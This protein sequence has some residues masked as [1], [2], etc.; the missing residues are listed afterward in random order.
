MWAPQHFAL[1][2]R[3]S[4]AGSALDAATTAWV[5]AVFAVDGTVVGDARKTLVNNLIVDLKADGVWTK[6][7]RLWLFAMENSTGALVDIVADSLATAVSSPTFTADAGYTGNGSSHIDSNFDPSTAGGNFAQN[8]ACLFAWSNSS[9]I[10]ASNIL[11]GQNDLSDKNVIIPRQSG[12]FYSSCNEGSSSYGC[13]GTVADSIGLFLVDRNAASGAG[14][15][16]GYLNGAQVA[17]GAIASGLMV[18]ANFSFLKGSA[19]GTYQCSAGGF[20]AHLTSIDSA[21]LYSR[22]RTYMT[23]VGVP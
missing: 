2:G 9:G 10:N 4:A 17:T 23:A 21:N 22:L 19:Y 11:C 5:D 18:S 14:C 12:T 13:S 3:R 7:D 15:E 1:L 20:G 8:S 6:L 16:L